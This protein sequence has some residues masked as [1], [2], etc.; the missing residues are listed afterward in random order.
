MRD[1]SALVGM[2]AVCT[3]TCDESGCPYEQD[4]CRLVQYLGGATFKVLPVAWMCLNEKGESDESCQ[5][6]G[7]PPDCL[8][9][10]L[11]ADEELKTVT[12]PLLAILDNDLPELEKSLN[13]KT[14]NGILEFWEFCNCEEE[15]TDISDVIRYG[16]R[17]EQ[18]NSKNSTDTPKEGEQ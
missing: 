14:K 10:G 4:Y 16:A 9:W 8:G 6:P 13:N 3:R 12:F 7:S 1:W 2:G 11:N 5:N 18:E 17:D 15:A